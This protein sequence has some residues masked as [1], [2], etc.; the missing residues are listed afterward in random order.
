MRRCG[1][2]N[3]AFCEVSGG[4]GDPTDMGMWANAAAIVAG[5]MFGMIHQQLG[6]SEDFDDDA[7]SAISHNVLQG[8]RMGRLETLK[9][10]AETRQ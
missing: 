8:I 2:L 4:V 7:A 10:A 9:Q 1:L 6:V 3:Q 5:S